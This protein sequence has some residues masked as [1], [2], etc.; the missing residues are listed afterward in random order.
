MA[1]VHLEESTLQ[2]VVIVTTLVITPA[3]GCNSELENQTSDAYLLLK[4]TLFIQVSD[5]KNIV[6]LH[7]E[8][9]FV[10]RLN[11]PSVYQLELLPINV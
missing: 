10:L 3:D 1:P 7:I 5:N 9:W 4:Q 2:G 6:M 8:L 11:M